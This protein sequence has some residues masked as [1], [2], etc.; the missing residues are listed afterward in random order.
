MTALYASVIKLHALSPGRLSQDPGQWANAAFY[1]LIGQ[2]DPDL[3]A[4][5]HA[6]NGRKP[7]TISALGGMSAR[8]G[9]EIEV[10]PGWETWLRVTTLGEE[11][12]A[13][14]IQRFIQAGA[15]PRLQLGPV[16]FAVSEVLTTPEAHP[17]AGYADA[18]NLVA[19][20]APAGRLVLEFLS[21]TAFHTG[22][23]PGLGSHNELFPVPH[24]VF[25]ASL[26]RVWRAFV[27]PE[28][29]ADYVE[30]LAAG[31]RISDY[32]LSTQTAHWRGHVY[33]GF[34]GRCA[35]DLRSLAE[36]ERT[37]LA[38]LA[39]FAFYAGVGGK[40]TQG[41]GQCRRLHRD[42]GTP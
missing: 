11:I 6:W 10:R 14:F 8:K 20:A 35:Y 5:L 4:A 34:T 27:S 24:L 7:F 42:D 39:D 15:R 30:D 26:A 19:R 1:K 32:D 9:R 23:L 25:G 37:L 2:V 13:T 16:E 17:L 36:D 28:L 31:A 3:A 40:T 33:K 41:M 12:F 29:D 18:G 21:P 38:A 22:S